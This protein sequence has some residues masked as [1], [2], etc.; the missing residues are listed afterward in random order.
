VPNGIH[1]N[2]IGNCNRLKVDA[3]NSLSICI[4]HDWPGTAIDSNWLP[5]PKDAFNLALR[6]YLPKPDVFTGNWRPPAVIRTN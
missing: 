6:M 1:R 3:D 4:Q 5:A 2:V